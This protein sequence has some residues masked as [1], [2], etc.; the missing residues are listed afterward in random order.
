VIAYQDRN[1]VNISREK[2]SKEEKL[3]K[4]QGS[5]DDKGRRRTCSQSLVWERKERKLAKRLIKI[6]KEVT[7]FG[8]DRVGEDLRDG[9]VAML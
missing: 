1:V 2:L 5:R 6:A 9:G 8:I 3:K 4:W 7:C